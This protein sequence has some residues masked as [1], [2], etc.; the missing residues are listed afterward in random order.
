M[1]EK[2]LAIPEEKQS[3]II[4]AALSIFGKHGYTKANTAE[5]CE[6]A[7]ISKGL[8]FHYFGSKKNLYLYLV[9]QVTEVMSQKYYAYM[10]QRPM[11]IFELLSESTV[12][13]LKIA[14]E[15]PDGYKIIYEA[16][17][18]PPPDVKDD[19]DQ[20][21]AGLFSNQRALFGQMVDVSLF[22]ETVDPKLGIDLI[23]A[24]AKGLYDLYLEDFKSFSADE[25][26]SRYD[27]IKE[28]MMAHFGLLKT[29]LYK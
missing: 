8:L 14:F 28:E 7:Q 22:K 18:N 4:E 15:M 16:Y 10:P 12:V 19:L 17:V 3:T 13:K 29:A 23:W 27:K 11:E 20:R 9:D 25:L 26:L 2:F 1:Y 5:I 24:C 6:K 21:L